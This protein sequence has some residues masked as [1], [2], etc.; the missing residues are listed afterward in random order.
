MSDLSLRSRY[1]NNPIH[2]EDEL[3]ERLERSGRSMIRI[4]IG[5][6][7]RYF[8]TPKYVIDA[9]VRALREGHSHYSNPF[10]IPELRQEVAAR[11][12]RMY[13][14]R[15]DE[16]DVIVTQGVSEAL[17][18][19]NALLLNDGDKAMV[20]RPYYT[21]YVPDLMLFGGKPMI[22]RYDEEID[23]SIRTDELERHIKKELKGSKKRPKYM[24]ITNPNNPTGTV[25]DERILK[26]IVEIAKNYGILLIS[27]EIYDEIIYNGAKFTS[28]SQL[29]K[30]VPHMILNGASKDFDATGFRLGFVVM[31]E[32]DR[33]TEEIKERLKKFTMI[34][35][36]VNTPAEYAMVDALKKRAEHRAAV[37]KMTEEI[38]RRANFATKMINDS[39]YMRSVVPRG[40]FYIFPK[41]DMKQL[42]LGDDSE[43]TR[44]LL[45]EEGVQLTRG[46]G[47]GEKNHIRI[48]ALPP[49]QVLAEAIDKINKF[50]KRHSK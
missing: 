38:A 33:K 5:D 28:I 19:F 9:C 26:E 7:A 21:Q 46:S 37:R 20:F 31:P 49:K 32:H 15:A 41:L 13:N 29:A 50:C 22:E 2:E 23:W 30:G 48:V 44:R 3:T 24:I 14:V 40:A 10:G 8:K 18:F 42:R 35:L 16:D 27:D 45:I 17:I 11:Y 43:F 12:R 39:D 34:R 47:F 6:P 25:L 1:A 36:S 4:N